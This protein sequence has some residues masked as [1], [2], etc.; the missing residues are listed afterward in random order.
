[1]THLDAPSSICRLG[2]ARG[3]ITPPVG[4]YHRMWGRATHGR[5]TGIHRPLTAT[6]LV[7]EPASGKSPER[8]VL[9]ALDHCLLW[10]PEMN[11]LLD[12]LSAATGSAA[13]QFAVT[14]SHT[15]AA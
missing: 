12:E 13:S 14:F 3:N 8:F 10:A 2:V 9:I 11:R 6:A 15:H 1:M 4:I 7:F 5:A